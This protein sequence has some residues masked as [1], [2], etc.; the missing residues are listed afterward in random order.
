MVN[1]RITFKLAELLNNRVFADVYNDMYAAEDVICTY[2]NYLGTENYKKGE[3]IEDGDH[4]HGKFYYAP[5]YGEVIDW[6]FDKGIVIEFIPA[7]TFA[8]RE[9]IAY[10]FSVYKISEDGLDTIFKE[11]MEMS[12][13]HLA[14]E[15]IVEKLLTEKYID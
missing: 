14:M 9:H 11:I 6:L 10:Y 8:L 13:F 4:V 7:F 12:S 2:E 1:D 5:T 3:L 15:T